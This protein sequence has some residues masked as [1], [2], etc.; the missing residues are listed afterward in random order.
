MLGRLRMSLDECESAYSMLSEAIFTPIRRG[1]DPVRIYN[2]LK[3]DCR[4]SEEPLENC[5]QHTVWSIGLSQD[6]LLRDTDPVSCKVFVCSTRGEDGSSAVI[7]SY[8]FRRHNP[9]YDI[10][11]IWEAARVTSAASTFFPNRQS[12]VD[13]AFRRNNPIRSANIESLDTWPGE[14]RLIISI[15]TGAAPGQPL[16]GNLLALAKRLKDLV[17]DTEQTNQDFRAENNEMV[18]KG[19]L[20]R[21]NV[22]HGL[23]DVGLEEYRA[24][25]KIAAVTDNYLDDPDIAEMVQACVDKLRSRGQRLGYASAGGWYV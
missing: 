10:C 19:R 24:V 1:T 6:A 2:F 13:G 7:R 8:D 18:R 9:L 15:G 25:N 20:Y 23:T 3:A 14:E 17:K 21:F 16:T 11:K 22:T 5:T 12:F 4:F